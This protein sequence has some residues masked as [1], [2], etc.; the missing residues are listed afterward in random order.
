[1]IEND[2]AHKITD[3]PAFGMTARVS[4]F[5]PNALNAAIFPGR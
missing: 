2:P 4:A 5:L 1:M 3:R